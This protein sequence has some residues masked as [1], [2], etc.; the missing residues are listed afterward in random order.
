M[1][2]E[3]LLA[4]PSDGFRYELVRGELRQ[5]APPGEEHGILVVNIALSL[6][7][8]VKTNRLGRVYAGKPGFKLTSSPDTVRALDLAFVSQENLDRLPPGTG[9]RPGA[10]DLAVEIISPSDRYTDVE[11][12]VFAWLEAGTRMVLVVNPRKRTVTVYRSLHDIHMLTE[13]EAIDGA[14]VVLGWR[15]PLRELFA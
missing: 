12:K 1:T 8:H 3:E 9:Y 13:A 11:E 15:L 10:P 4:M 7:E 5:M 14:D 6:G 2:A